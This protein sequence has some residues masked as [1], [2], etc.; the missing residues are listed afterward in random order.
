MA[1]GHE[2]KEGAKDVAHDVADTAKKAKAAAA[3]A[4]TKKE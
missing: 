2:V 3:D 1:A 4:T